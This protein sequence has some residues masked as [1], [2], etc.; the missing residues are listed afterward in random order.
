MSSQTIAMHIPRR[1]PRA[2]QALEE[3]ARALP[4]AEVGEPD[5]AGIFE[6]TLEAQDVEEALEQ[7]WDAVAATGADDDVVFAEHADIPD[8]WRERIARS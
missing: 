7:V 3:L 8:H 2:G 1:T 6:I 4:G 5:D